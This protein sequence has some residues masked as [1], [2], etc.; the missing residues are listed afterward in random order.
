MGTL[1]HPGRIALTLLALAAIALPALAGQRARKHEA[2]EE[3]EILEQQW[4]AAEL[5]GDAAAMDK[6]L[7]DD[8]LGITGT[9]QAVTKLQQLDR[10]RTRQLSITHLD[11]SDVKIKLVGQQVAIVTSQAQIEGTVDNHPLNG[12]YRSTRV[13][14]R[15]PGG[16]WK[17][18][19][20][21]ATPVRSS[22]RHREDAHRAAEPAPGGGNPPSQ[23]AAQ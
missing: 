18:T 6:L 7:S 9:G 13:Y 1:A 4:R 20:F 15:L 11:I 8:Y 12:N 21:E 5:N 19:N 2:R 3:I 17:L 10:M 22:Q 23:F 14:Q 16:V